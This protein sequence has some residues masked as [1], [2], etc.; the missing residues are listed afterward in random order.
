MSRSPS[1]SIEGIELRGQCGVSQ[2]ERSVGQ[3]LI[4]DVRLEPVSCPGMESDE[5]DDTVDYAHVVDVVRSIV[6]GNEFRLI[7][8]LASVI[9]D[10]LWDEFDLLFL[11]VSVTKP[12]PP[13]AIPVRA[14]RVEVVRTT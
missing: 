7:E 2:E 4:I 14:V 5:I 6:S 9:A 11:E 13:V 8:R 10:T 12:A 3:T 1:I